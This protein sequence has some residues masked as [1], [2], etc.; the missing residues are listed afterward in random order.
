MSTGKLIAGRGHDTR[1][2]DEPSVFVTSESSLLEGGGGVQWC[3]REYIS[4]LHA[5]FRQVSCLGFAVDRRPVARF[6]RL[7]LASPF[8]HVHHP[9]TVGEIIRKADA[10]NTTWIL[11]NNM[12]A[13]VLAP[14]LKAARKDFKLI[15]LSHGTELVDEVNNLRIFGDE[16][17]SLRRSSRWYG[18]LV[19]LELSVRRSLDAV[20]CISEDDQVFERWLGAKQTEFIP[21][22][23]PVR[24]IKL[25]PVIGR[26]GTVSTLDHGPNIDG[27]RQL[28]THLDTKPGV[29][30][31][32]VGGPDHVGR[33]LA[34]R[35]RSI[36]F[37]GRLSEPELTKE[38]E[39]WAA[40]VN[41]IF[42][43]ARGASTKVA[44]ALGWGLAVLTTPQGARGYR[45]DTEAL[46]LSDSPMSL[47]ARCVEFASLSADGRMRADVVTRLAP[48]VGEAADMIRQLLSRLSPG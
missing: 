18:R 24:E 46:P 37:L 12:D 6:L 10:L 27:L 16:A 17:S 3:T 4:T 35:H 25:R 20:V 1:V 48:T 22:Q 15:Y 30:L 33:T 34:A 32:L 13:A 39:S 38:A 43:Q 44:T 21:R 23:V 47:A 26:V 31:R 11:L 7:A 19:E 42:C 9:Q 29:E 36:R 40:F 2:L 5:V 41:P 45:W 14:R 8:R 28:A